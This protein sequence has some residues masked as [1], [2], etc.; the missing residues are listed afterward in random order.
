MILLKR[1][2]YRH[3]LFNRGRGARKVGRTETAPESNASP[4]RSASV[5]SPEMKENPKAW[6][7]AREKVSAVSMPKYSQPSPKYVSCVT[8]KV[9]FDSTTRYCTPRAGCVYA[10]RCMSFCHS[11]V[12]SYQVDTS[13][14]AC[15]MHH[16]ATRTDRSEQTLALMSLKGTVPTGASRPYLA[17]SV[18]SSVAS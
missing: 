5:H 10:I 12:F 2:V 16:D 9:V 3:L 17:S 7:R 13:Q 8:D 4:H 11:H 1:D 15:V 18:S 6:E 14:Y